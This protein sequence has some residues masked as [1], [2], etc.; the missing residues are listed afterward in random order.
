MRAALLDCHYWYYL[1]LAG[2]SN[3][4]NGNELEVG[5]GITGAPADEY[6]YFL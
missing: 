1:Q 6:Y 2:G 4:L 3:Y 5:T